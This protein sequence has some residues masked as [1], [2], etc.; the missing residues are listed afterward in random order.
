[1]SELPA[2]SLGYQAVVAEFFLAL[3][4]AGLLLSP[5]DQDLVA[6]WERRGL[7]VPVVCRGLRR[8]LAA[9]AEER[10]GPVRSLRSLRFAV[11]EEWRAYRSGRV[12]DAPEPEDEEE[13]AARRLANASAD[14]VRAEAQGGALAEVY[15]GARRELLAHQVF[16]GSPLDRVEAGLI[17]ADCRILTGWVASLPRPERA[18][19]GARVRLLAGARPRGESRRAHR[20]TLRAHL[21]ELGRQAGLSCLRGSV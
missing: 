11:E 20:E 16:P 2:E 18:A 6:E 4:G 21:R 7:P 5:L 13:A 14:L 1:M 12:G 10:P 9:L 3:R 19:L 8:G 17:A 15:R